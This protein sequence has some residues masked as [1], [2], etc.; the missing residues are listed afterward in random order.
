MANLYKMFLNTD[1]TMI[2]VNPLAET[3][4]GRGV[5]FSASCLLCP[6]IACIVVRACAVVVCDAKINFD[7]NAAFRQPDIFA[8]RDVTQVGGCNS[9]VVPLLVA[10]IRPLVAGGSPRSRSC[11]V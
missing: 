5:P 10:F 7:D 2:E 6:Q 9:C 11:E 1:A 8:M 3:P 4:D